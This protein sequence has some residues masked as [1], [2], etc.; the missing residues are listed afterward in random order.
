MARKRRQDPS[1]PKTQ[2]HP[3]RLRTVRAFNKM[4]GAQVPKPDRYWDLG[5]RFGG[6]ET[7]PP[8]RVDTI[9]SRIVKKPRNGPRS[10]F[11][12]RSEL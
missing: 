10:L 12:D 8:P 9:W 3:K 11:P 1:E 7:A 2:H 4:L 5:G 6:L